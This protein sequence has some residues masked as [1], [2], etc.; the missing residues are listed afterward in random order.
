MNLSYCAETLPVWSN[1][2]NGSSMTSLLK[3]MLDRLL[4][5]HEEAWIVASLD[6]AQTSGVEGQVLIRS[7][8]I[9]RAALDA[10]TSN[11]GELK[12]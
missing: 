4:V 3:M 1:I 11:V 7:Q 8:R 5:V 9:S 2:A 12:T 6:S 10:A